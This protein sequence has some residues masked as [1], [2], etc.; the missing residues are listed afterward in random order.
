MSFSEKM[1]QLK[2]DTGY[3]FCAEENTS[4]SERWSFLLMGTY[5]VVEW[6][7]YFERLMRQIYM[8]KLSSPYKIPSFDIS[9]L[10]C[11]R[12]K[13]INSLKNLND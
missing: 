1:N 13:N 8:Y 9:V 7:I 6:F 5:G 2:N 3:G 11:E 4:F 10:I 12:E